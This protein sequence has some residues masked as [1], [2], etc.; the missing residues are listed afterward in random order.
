M[1]FVYLILAIVARLSFWV[2]EPVLIV[3]SVSKRMVFTNLRLDTYF[4][5]VALSI[6]Q[7]ANVVGMDILNDTMLKDDSRAR[8]IYGHKWVV[9][10]NE[11]FTISY[12][13]AANQRINNLT[14]FGEFWAWFLDFVDKDHLKKAL[15][16]NEHGNK[17]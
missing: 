1:N 17:G 11:D 13:L 12:V 9:F 14:W 2:L 3:Y 6:D 8:W 15:Q 5:K 4:Y 7:H 16:N 10:G